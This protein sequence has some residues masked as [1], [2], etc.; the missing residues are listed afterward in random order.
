MVSDPNKDLLLDMNFRTALLE[1]LDWD[2]T[3]SDAL[4]VYLQE[5]ITLNTMLPNDILEH[6]KIEY[7]EAAQILIKQMFVD[8]YV[9]HGLYINTEDDHEH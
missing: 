9:N 7:G 5:V 2:E 3:Q 8:E 1:S 4:L 6:I